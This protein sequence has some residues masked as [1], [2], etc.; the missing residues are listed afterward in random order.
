VAGAGRVPEAVGAIVA[1]ERFRAASSS[2]PAFAEPQRHSLVWR[3]MNRRLKLNA[4]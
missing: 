4:I 1:H 2:A 3:S